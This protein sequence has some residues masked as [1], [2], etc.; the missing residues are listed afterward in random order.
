MFP[1]ASHTNMKQYS[2]T[3]NNPTPWITDGTMPVQPDLKKLNIGG[4]VHTSAKG[5]YFS[6]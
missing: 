4:G 5:A 6:F 2:Y 1:I 3:V